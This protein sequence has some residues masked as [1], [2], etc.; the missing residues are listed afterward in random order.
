MDKKEVCEIRKLFDKN[1]CRIDRMYGCYVDGQK[2]KIAELKD[3]LHSLEEEERFKYCELFQKALSG[4]IGKTLFNIDFPLEEEREGGHQEALYRLLKSGLKD[5]D[6]VSL[7]FDRVIEA[8]RS[9]DKYLL[10][11]VHGNYDIPGKTGDGIRMEDASEEVYSF[12]EFSLC[13]VS[14]LRDGLCYDAKEQAF[15]NRVEDWVVQKPELGFLYPAFHE[16]SADIH[17]ALWYAKN[18]KTRHDELAEALF[19]IALPRAETKEKDAFHAVLEAALSEHCDYEA[20]TNINEAVAEIA[21]A[22]KENG[23]TARVGKEELKQI[24]F[25]NGADSETIERLEK[26]YEEIA[27]SEEPFLAENIAE[28]KKISVSSDYMDMKID[29]GASEVIQT[30]VIDGTEYF[31]IPVRDSVTVNGIRIRSRAKGVKE[32]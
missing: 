27:G 31:L 8:Y 22:G 10:L 29:A 4:R 26:V 11:L 5:A 24:F 28:R 15:F 9:S 32:A 12:L 20:I 2:G 16:R 17:A 13:P 19:G 23:E 14:L 6:S 25:E 3:V 7:F 30:R 21:E 18:E 1:D